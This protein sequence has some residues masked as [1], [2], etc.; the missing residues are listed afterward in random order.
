MI[1][2]ICGKSG[3]G[4]STLSNNIIELTNSKAVHLDIDKVGHNALMIDEVKEELV[5]SFGSF[6]IRESNIDRKKLG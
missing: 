4:K 6:I 5:N 1:I 3:C 2:G